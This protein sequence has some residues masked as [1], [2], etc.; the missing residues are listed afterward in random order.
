M[1]DEVLRLYRRRHFEL[2]V[3]HFHKKL[4]A[5]HGLAVSYTWK[6]GELQGAGLVKWPP[7]RGTH[8]K[9]GQHWLLPGMLI[10]WGRRESSAMFTTGRRW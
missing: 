3:K 4:S 8:R 7:R 9:R 5:E 1:L 2:N 10:H 6:K